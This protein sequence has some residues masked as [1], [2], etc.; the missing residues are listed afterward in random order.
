MSLPTAQFDHLVVFVTDIEQA[1]RDFTE[2][3]FQVTPG[4]SHGSTENA[5]VIFS[6]QTYIELLALKP[7]WY[8]PLI[9][10]A[11]KLRLL[12]RQAQKKTNIYARLL[13][14]IRNKSGPVDWCVRVDNLDTRL[15]LWQSLGLEVLSTEPFTRTRID[16]EVAEWK[17]AG[18]RAVDLP[19][20][21][22]DM[23]AIDIRVPTAGNSDHSN[24]A[25]ALIDVKLATN[26]TIAAEKSLQKALVIDPV[27]SHNGAGK[28][29]LGDTTVSFNDNQPGEPRVSLQLAYNGEQPLLLDNRKTY[30]VK[31]TLVPSQ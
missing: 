22:Q 17:L 29:S 21:L 8:R 24:G 20:L 14:W 6:N 11:V 5:L 1:S 25:K 3:G 27:P 10:L 18:S 19:F 31:I 15:T 13:G 28:F 9:R 2:L 12:Q 4:G 23:S 30:G 16:G 26:H 7:S